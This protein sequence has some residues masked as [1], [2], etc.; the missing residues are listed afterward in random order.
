MREFH[1]LGLPTDE[2]HDGEI[3]VAETKVFVTEPGNHPYRIE[4]LRY[5]SDSPVTGPLRM[6]PHLAFTTDD[7]EREISGKNVILGP[8]QAM[9]NVVAAFIYDA[10]TVVEFMQWTTEEKTF[11]PK[12]N[13]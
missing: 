4:Y 7:L 12:G 1:H 13:Q 8:F 5:E 9:E 2:K 10:G 6:Q 3:Y 11:A